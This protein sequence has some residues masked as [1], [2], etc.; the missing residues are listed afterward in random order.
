MSLLNQKL[1][2]GSDFND[3]KT[4]FIIQKAYQ[5]V[6]EVSTDVLAMMLKDNEL[7]P[8][9][10]YSNSKMAEDNRIISSESANVLREANG[11][12]NLIVHI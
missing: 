11:I 8:M 6:V 2:S 7:P 12:R 5:K 9:D 1:Q 4:L 3:T 10:N